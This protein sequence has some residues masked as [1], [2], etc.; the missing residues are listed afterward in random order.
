MNA[1]TTC[2]R[3][4]NEYKAAEKARK[5]WYDAM[6]ARGYTYCDYGYDLIS[7]ADFEGWT[8][9]DAQG[10]LL[11]NLKQFVLCG[12]TFAEVYRASK[13]LVKV[14]HNKKEYKELHGLI[15]KIDVFRGSR[16]WENE[17]VRLYKELSNKW[18]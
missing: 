7:D 5:D 10:W 16:K 2:N 8:I 17:A 15:V 12:E 1:F 18:N 4:R 3:R 14:S 13:R 9:K 6:Y 11:Y